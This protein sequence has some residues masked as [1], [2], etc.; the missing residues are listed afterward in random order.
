M[1]IVSCFQV[2]SGVRVGR[3][4]KAGQGHH[5]TSKA[6]CFMCVCIARWWVKKEILISARLWPNLA[7]I[8]KVREIKHR[9]DTPSK[10]RY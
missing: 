4:K 3:T 2:L 10:P 5:K 7:R 9:L 8:L 1:G 6:V